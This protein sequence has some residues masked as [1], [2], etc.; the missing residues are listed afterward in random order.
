MWGGNACMRLHHPLPF[1][2]SW[3]LLSSHAP[4]LT[5]TAA[6]ARNSVTATPSRVAS[7]LRGST[8]TTKLIQ[9]SRVT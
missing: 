8:N 2:G 1:A 7:S 4:A 6:S 3:R 9:A 5:W